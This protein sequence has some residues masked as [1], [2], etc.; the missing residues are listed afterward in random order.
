MCVWRPP[1]RRGCSAVTGVCLGPLAVQESRRTHWNR[2]PTNHSTPQNA[3]NITNVW[4]PFSNQNQYSQ[5]W[6]SKKK[7]SLLKKQNRL[8]SYIR[9]DTTIFHYDSL[10][11]FCLLVLFGLGVFLGGGWE[12]IAR[13]F[14]R[15]SCHTSSLDSVSQTFCCRTSTYVPV[16]QKPIITR[17]IVPCTINTGRMK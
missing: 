16:T 9:K 13:D 17:R 2:N 14:F 1:W 10:L 3:K 6:F 5:F 12:G 4:L 15:T 7:V 8:Q 11:G